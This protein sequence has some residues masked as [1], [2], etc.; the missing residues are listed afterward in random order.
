MQICVKKAAAE[1]LKPADIKKRL[2]R[3]GKPTIIGSRQR[4]KHVRIRGS[5]EK[6]ERKYLFFTYDPPLNLN[7]LIT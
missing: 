1:G 6:R 3:I 2:L 5:G 7:Q 4:K